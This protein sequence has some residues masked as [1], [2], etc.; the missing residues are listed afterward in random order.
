MAT[1]DDF[2]RGY[3]CAVAVLLRE[4]GCPDTHIRS[5]FSQGGD[6]AKAD[7]ED[8]EL[9]TQH[10]LLTQKPASTL[11]DVADFLGTL[12]GEDQ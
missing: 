10:G 8:V 11:Q 6:A 4:T 3:F 5:L 2:A 7:A 1:K 12:T 9:F